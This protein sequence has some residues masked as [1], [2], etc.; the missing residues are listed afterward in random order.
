MK[1]VAATAA[2]AA[3][4]VVG[5]ATSAS[6]L[7]CQVADKPVSAG[8]GTEA[9]LTTNAAGRTVFRGAFLQVSPDTGFF[10]RGGDK[11]HTEDLGKQFGFA[12]AQAECNGPDDHGVIDPW[13]VVCGEGGDH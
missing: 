9:D 7:W 13:G 12:P 11:S 3:A 1:K 5:S 4:M 2:L 8:A 10:V 6:A